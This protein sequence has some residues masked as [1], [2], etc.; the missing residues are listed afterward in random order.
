MIGRRV[1]GRADSGGQWRTMPGLEK[2][3]FVSHRFC[4]PFFLPW[5]LG[6]L[7][8]LG[9]MGGGAHNFEV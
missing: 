4:P 6:S 1:E 9:R 7:L 5:V 8:I 3:M 2:G